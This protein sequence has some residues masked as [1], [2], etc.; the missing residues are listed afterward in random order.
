MGLLDDLKSRADVQREV[1]QASEASL[2]E[3]ERFYREEIQ[4]R[5]VRAYQFFTEMADQLNYLKMETRHDYPLLPEGKTCSLRHEGYKVVI[6]SSKNLK[7]LDLN[8]QCSLDKP[9]EF[10]IIGK[11]AV[12]NHCD[13][14]DRYYFKYERKIKKDARLEIESARFRIEGPLPMKVVL[15]V[16][17]DKGVIKLGIRNFTDPGVS[18]YVL[19]PEQFDEAFQDRLGKFILREEISLFE[20]TVSDDA[21]DR[22]RK[23]IQQEQAQRE[24]E[25]REA[26]ERQAVEEAAQKESSRKEQLKKAVNEQV[27]EKKAKLK[28]M[29]NKLKDQAGFNKQK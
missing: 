13:R 3:R 25:L 28:T 17:V 19:K 6:D 26:E 5:M 4:P 14:L 2:A 8:F 16:D 10:D 7:Q 1:E 29:F 22:L 9:L 27:N 15:A 20:D 24:Q 11:D 23:Q 21:R 12:L 18:Q